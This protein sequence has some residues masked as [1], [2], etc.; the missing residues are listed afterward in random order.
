MRSSMVVRVC[1][2]VEFCKLFLLLFQYRHQGQVEFEVAVSPEAQNFALLKNSLQP[3]LE[4]YMLHGYRADSSENRV[5]IRSSVFS[6]KNGQKTLCLEI[7]DNGHGIAA[8]R[9]AQLQEL[10]KCREDTKDQGIGLKNVHLRIQMVFG[11]EYGCSVDSV[12][13]KG[14][15]V[16]LMMPAITEKEL[17]KRVHCHAD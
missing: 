15:I 10:L 8:Q 3:I 16:R 13:G 7:E 5:S 12:E 6:T 14:T 1:D 17:S 11:A 9:L 2:E 4:N